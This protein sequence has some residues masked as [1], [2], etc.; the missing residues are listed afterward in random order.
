MK[1]QYQNKTNTTGTLRIY[2]GMN[3]EN[4]KNR[5]IGAVK[6]LTFK[7]FKDKNYF[8]VDWEI[9]ENPFPVYA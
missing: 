5:S 9:P 6:H 7:K 4:H 8:I 1:N 2:H 3:S